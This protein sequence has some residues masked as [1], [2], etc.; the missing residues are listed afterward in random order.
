MKIVKLLDRI[1]AVVS[2]VFAYIAA[3]ALLFNV[4][5]ILANVVLRWFGSSVIGTEEYVSLGE[6]VL[7]FLALGYTQYSHGLVHVCFFMTKIPG[8]GSMLAWTIHMWLASLVVALLVY[9]TAQVIPSVTQVTQS[10]LIPLQPFYVVLLVG[11]VVYLIVQ[12]FEAIKC[13]VGLF[14][15]EIRAEVME[16]WPA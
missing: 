8:I 3:C 6:V 4:V 12:L 5:I 14:N 11:C 16:N 1:S 13:T 2:K 10:L 9:E 7:I 15:K